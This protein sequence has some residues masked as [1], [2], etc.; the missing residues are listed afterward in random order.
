MV[1]S[2]DPGRVNGG[3]GYGVV[4]RLDCST[5]VWGMDRVYPGL[6]G[7]CVQQP[8]LLVLKLILIVN[9]AAQYIVDGGSRFRRELCAGHY[10]FNHRGGLSYK[11]HLPNIP[12]EVAG[13]D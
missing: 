12:P 5:A 11:D 7:G 8:L 4:D 1:W 13:L 9:R 6:D 3:K 2:N 10:S